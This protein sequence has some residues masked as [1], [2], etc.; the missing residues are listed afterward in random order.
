MNEEAGYRKRL[1][2]LL[3]EIQGRLNYELTENFDALEYGNNS[4]QDDMVELIA[5]IFN[6][7]RNGKNL[8]NIMKIIMEEYEEERASDLSVAIQE[9]RR[10]RKNKN[11]VIIGGKIV[12]L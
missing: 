9:I 3:N 11:I 5:T 8:A 4:W 6:E 7:Y 10:L 2:L 1:K 12:I